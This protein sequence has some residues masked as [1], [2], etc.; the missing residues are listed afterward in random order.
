MNEG[1]GGVAEDYCLELRDRKEESEL[2]E[3]GNELESAKETKGNLN[4]LLPFERE[5]DS[6]NNKLRVSGLMFWSEKILGFVWFAMKMR[7]VGFGIKR[8]SWK[9]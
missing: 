3:V 1:P 2:D 8:V 9:V 4:G 6:Y 5:I 7:T